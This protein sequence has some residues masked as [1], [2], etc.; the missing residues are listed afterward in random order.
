MEKVD[1]SK[2][3]KDLYSANQK[4][5]EVVV[6]EGRYLCVAGQGEP[7]G[8]AYAGAF[9]QL[10][11]V[12][13]TLKYAHKAGDDFDFAIG[14]IECLWYDGPEV[15]MSEWRWRL[16]IRVPDQIADAELAETKAK[17][18]AEKGTDVS[19][20]QLETLTEGRC[21][22]TLHLGPYDRLHETYARLTDFAGEN[23]LAMSGPA[24][25]IYLSDPRRSEPERLK[26]IV[27][28]PVGKAA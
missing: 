21:L 26:T 28:L 19:G 18:T 27:R 15:P 7:G 9:G 10:F 13:Y 24:H 3:L 2:T 20:V 25:E 1:F 22:Q 16:M 8:D 11:P 6:E 23:G 17:I 5:K 4:I 14:K 12:A